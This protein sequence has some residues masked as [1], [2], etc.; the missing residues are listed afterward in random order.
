MHH[1]P[2][3]LRNDHEEVHVLGLIA[4]I[5]RGAV[6]HQSLSH[7]TLS[8]QPVRCASIN[9]KDRSFTNVVMLD[10]GRLTSTKPGVVNFKNTI[11][12]MTS[13]LGAEY[14]TGLR[15]D[16]DSEAVRDQVMD[17]V[18][19]SFRPEF[20][21]RVD[22]IILIHRLHRREMGA[23]VDIQLVRLEKLLAERKITLELGGDARAWL[24]DKGYDP[25]YGARPLKRAIQR[26]IQDPLSER[27][28]SGDFPDGSK[29][30]VSAGSDRLVFAAN[31]S[32]AAPQAA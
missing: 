16:Q 30:L 27:I 25:V 19:A 12:I 31:T 28:L 4:P 9:G 7:G 11:I 24:A 2:L 13:N 20:L 26:F 32:E 8:S 5:Q 17:V 6:V 10:D 15:D 21:N 3:A 29:V 22:E 18:K 1:H 14:L 23:I